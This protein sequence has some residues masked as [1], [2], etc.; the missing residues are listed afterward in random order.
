M[1][2]MAVV[3][4]GDLDLEDLA[5][6]HLPWWYATFEPNFHR[7]TC[8][9]LDMRGNTPAQGATFSYLRLNL[10]DVVLI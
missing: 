5:S 8:L 2:V 3:A 9:E 1:T 4:D 10:A 6:E 7:F